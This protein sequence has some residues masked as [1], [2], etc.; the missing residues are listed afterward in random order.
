MMESKYKDCGRRIGF[1]CQR[2]GRCCIDF[3]VPLGY[4]DLLLIK[5]KTGCQIVVGQNGIVWLK[6]DK[7]DLAIRAIQ[8]IE[9]NSHITGLTEKIKE[10]LEN[11]TKGD[12][13]D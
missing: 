3:F 12:R 9:E 1:G 7:E 6:G 13:H 8:E 11:E 2:C 4:E 10:M 5:E